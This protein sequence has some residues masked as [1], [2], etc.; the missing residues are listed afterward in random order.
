M[1]CD[2]LG[3]NYLFLGFSMQIS[4]IFLPIFAGKIGASKLEIGIIGGSF[5][6]AYLF[7]SVF[8]GRL[9]D[10]KG[11]VLFIRLGLGLATVSYAAQLLAGT[12]FFLTLVRALLGLCIAMS[13]AAVMAFNFEVGGRTSRFT[14]L[15][16]L[17][18]LAGGVLAIFVQDYRLTLLSQFRRLWSCFPYLV[19]TPRTK[20]S[21]DGKTGCAYHA[22][23]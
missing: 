3:Y 21:Q 2:R 13:D 6:F 5:G 1:V 7:S 22:P 16:A 8:S 23:P 10:I 4:G 20:E 18:W 15:G 19:G 14:S 17:G 9:S 11:R 12:P